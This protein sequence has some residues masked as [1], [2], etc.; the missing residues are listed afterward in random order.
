ML[1]PE[2]RLVPLTGGR[3]A[4]VPPSPANVADPPRTAVPRAEGFAAFLIRTGAVEAGAVLRAL[5]LQR[6]HG[7]RIEDALLAGGLVPEAPLY[8]AMGRYWA[9]PVVDL[10]VVP[11]DPRLI[12]V[13]GAAECL[14][15]GMMPWRRVG[16][17]TVV[18][19]AHPAECLRRMPAL[20]AAFGQVTM[21]LAPPRA[22]AAAITAAA[23]PQLARAAETRVPVALSCRGGRPGAA[24]LVLAAGLLALGLALWLAPGLAFGLL[25]GW[26][27]ATMLLVSLLKLAALVAGWRTPLQAAPPLADEDLPVVSVIVALY[28][29]ADIAPRLIRRLESLDYPRDRLDVVLA[30]EERDSATRGA[31]ARAVLPGWM[32]VAV[33]PD[34]PLRTKPRALNL[35]LDLCR[36]AIIGIYDAEDAPDPGQLR[37]VAARFAL[38]GPRV[39]CLQGV[40]D[41]Y[42]PR[43]NAMARL[44]TLEYGG[45]FRVVLPGLARLGLPVPLGGT[46]LFLRRGVLETLGGWDA[47]NVT[48][49]ADLGIRLAR[50]GHVTELVDTVTHEEACCRPWPWVRQRS[51]WIKGYMLTWA[52]HMR[53]PRQLWRDLGPRGFAAFQVLFLATLTQFLL[54]PLLWSFWLVPMGVALPDA[55]GLWQFVAV[56]FL[57]CE[58]VNLAVVLRGRQRSGQPVAVW[59]APL[60][61][62]YFPL[63]TLAAFKALWEV[64]TRPYFWDKT[65]HGL[66]DIAA[67]CDAGARAEA[68]AA[69][70]QQVALPAGVRRKSAAPR[71]GD[72]ADPA[73]SI[74]REATL[75]AFSHLPQVA[76]PGQGGTGPGGT[77]PAFLAAAAQR[78]RSSPASTRS[79]VS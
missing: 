76:P 73:G 46:T 9:V 38:A 53:R 17:R 25:V 57:L 79:R 50:H 11:P 16:D 48:E 27:L 7:G 41:F 10:R 37:R 31:L 67:G 68:A 43:S 23:G 44:F 36:G 28:R 33:V 45:W 54:A 24:A 12:G 8:A 19:T 2:S 42:N 1:L 72:P 51:R 47:H 70:S 71:R 29:E 78:V 26:T 21:A 58:A 56:L 30:V 3:A 74:G 14:R 64:G 5:A 77:A 55:A 60:M 20:S 63:A 34:G 52:V 59:W 75:T 13:I 40:L 66:Y 69:A 4:A 61:H 18:V 39:A 6:R 15:E 49:D 22:I 62:L 32:R 65:A 35:A